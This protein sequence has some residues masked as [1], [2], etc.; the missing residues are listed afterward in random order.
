MNTKYGTVFFG[1]KLHKDIRVKR[2]LGEYRP[3]LNAA[4]LTLTHTHGYGEINLLQV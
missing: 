2:E 3:S 4:A 1:F